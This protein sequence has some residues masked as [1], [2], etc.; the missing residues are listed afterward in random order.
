MLPLMRT[1]RRLRWV[2]VCCVWSGAS[3]SS[4]LG[5]PARFSFSLTLV[6]QQPRAEVVVE[7]A[8]ATAE[9]ALAGLALALLVVDAPGPVPAVC[10]FGFRWGR[11]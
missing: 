9:E 2:V 3:V 1:T 6:M 8:V 11:K 5:V 4:M 7:V 10:L